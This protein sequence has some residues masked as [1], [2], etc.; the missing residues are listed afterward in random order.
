MKD[1]AKS[2]YV[3]NAKDK[4][5]T[6]LKVGDIVAVKTS[7]PSLNH[8]KIVRISGDQISVDVT[9]DDDIWTT[10]ARLAVKMGN[11]KVGNSNKAEI[12]EKKKKEGATLKVDNG[13]KLE[14]SDGS[15][16][17]KT[18]F[19]DDYREAHNYTGNKKLYWDV[20]NYDWDVGIFNGQWYITKNGQKFKGPFR[21]MNEA[22]RY[23]EGHKWEFEGKLAKSKTGN[24]SL[25]EYMA[26]KPRVINEDKTGAEEFFKKLSDDVKDREKK[27]DADIEKVGNLSKDELLKELDAEEKLL[28]VLKERGGEKGYETTPILYRDAERRIQDLK[29]KLKQ[30]GNKVG[31]SASEDKFAYVMREFDEGKLKTPDGK[32]V[33]D[34]AQAKAI[35]YSES[36]KTENGLARARKAIK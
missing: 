16:Y 2:I 10:P 20:G 36:K 11:A 24:E 4:N 29:N 27:D 13:Q 8:G 25:G 32:V 23:L 26:K 33:T 22:V 9:G 14:F 30:I 35:A 21:S 3:G 31:N 5:G 34:P 28:K 17:V 15:T 12:I 18:S 1:F 19:S 7:D 6:E